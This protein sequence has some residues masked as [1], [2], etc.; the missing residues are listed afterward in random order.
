MPSI[1]QKDRMNQ[2]QFFINVFA[3]SVCGRTTRGRSF[4][5]ANADAKRLSVNPLLRFMI[6]VWVARTL[7]RLFVNHKPSQA[8]LRTPAREKEVIKIVVSQQE[9]D[10]GT[11]L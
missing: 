11:Y 3:D 9:V 4:C 7:L 5:E 10:G 8:S 2:P 1:K 6:L